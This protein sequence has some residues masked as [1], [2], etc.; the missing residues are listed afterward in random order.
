MYLPTPQ[1]LIDLDACEEQHEL[2]AGLFFDGDLESTEQIKWTP[3]HLQTA[4][5]NAV[6][7]E[8]GFDQGLGD[9][10]PRWMAL[11]HASTALFY[12]RDT[13]KG[14]RDDTRNA[15][16]DDSEEALA[17][18]RVV[19]RGP[20]DDTRNAVLGNAWHAYIYARDIDKGP[21]DDTRNAVAGSGYAGFYALYID[22]V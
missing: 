20:H 10:L 14:P 22:M 12:A 4:I 15:A 5:D 7:L 2:W 17:Y 18:A 11:G 9:T 3:E 16:C 6:D 1:A 21:H 19:D 13:D 8:W